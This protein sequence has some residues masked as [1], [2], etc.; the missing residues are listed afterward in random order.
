MQVETLAFGSEK[1]AELTANLLADQT[2]EPFL[3]LLAFYEG[4]A[5]GHIL[6]TRAYAEGHKT[7]PVISI[8]APLAVI[9]RFQKKGIGGMLIK[10]GHEIL[11]ERG[12][13]LVFVLGHMDYYPKFGYIPDAKSYGYITPYPIP[14]EFKNAWMVLPLTSGALKKG[15]GKVI[16]ADSLLRPEYW[17]E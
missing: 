15:K 16:M 2:A 10:A 17:R 12:T 6:F 13:D 9:P 5:I 3:S 7:K 4:E 11:K 1:E 8:L 14:E